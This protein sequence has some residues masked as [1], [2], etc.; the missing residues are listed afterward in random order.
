MTRKPNY[1]E[2]CPAREDRN[3]ANAQKSTG[4]RT[5]KGKARVPAGWQAGAAVIWD[6]TPFRFSPSLCYRAPRLNRT[7]RSHKVS[8]LYM[9]PWLR[10]SWRGALLE[11]P[12]LDGSQ[13]PENEAYQSFIVRL[14]VVDFA[15]IFDNACHHMAH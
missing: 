13:M 10:T 6:V 2:Y 3:R 7:T 12:R 8:G 14:G 1:P 5:A 4:P 15:N 9:V 11:D